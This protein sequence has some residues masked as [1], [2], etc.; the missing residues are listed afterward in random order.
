M[1]GPISAL[2]SYVFNA[3]RLNGRATRSEYVWP[4]LAYTLLLILAGVADA[5]T[6]VAATQDGG[7]PPLSPLAYWSVPLFLLCMIPNFTVA[8]RRLHDSGKSGAWMLV[9]FVPMVGGIVFLILMLLPSQDRENAWGQPRGPSSESGT[10]RARDHK[11]SALDSYALLL[12]SE[13]EPSPEEVARRKQE[14]HD[15]FLRNVSRRTAS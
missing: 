15:Y 13:A 3:F 14:V 9:M 4:A 11:A 8:I 10:P 1:V 7:M 5:M 2:E 6:L 12:Q